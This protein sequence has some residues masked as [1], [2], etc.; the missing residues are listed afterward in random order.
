MLDAY[1]FA[2]WGPK[3]VIQKRQ[4]AAPYHELLS[5]EESLAMD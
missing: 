3:L 1:D 2:D 4:R 5:W